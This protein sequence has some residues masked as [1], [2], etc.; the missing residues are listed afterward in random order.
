[1]LDTVLPAFYDTSYR[2]KLL[3]LSFKPE[4]LT[5]IKFCKLYVN[6]KLIC[7]FNIDWSQQCPKNREELYF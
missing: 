7:Y 2:D 3:I 6:V 4:V 5:P 1:M